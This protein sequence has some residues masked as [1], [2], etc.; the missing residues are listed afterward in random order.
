MSAEASYARA[1]A[2]ILVQ[3]STWN[4][5]EVPVRNFSWRVYRPK[6]ETVPAQGWKLHV[7]CTED[8]IDALVTKVIAPLIERKTS[9]KLPATVRGL[10]QLNDGVGGKAQR[11]KIVTIYPRDEREAAELLR[12]L[13]E[14][15]PAS[16]SPRVA[17]EARLRRES[18]VSARY[19]AFETHFSEDEFGRPER[20]IIN[21]AWPSHR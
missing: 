16:S 4:V 10:R 20:M 14:A 13:D 9:F 11:G 1:L 19:G 12:T 5:E 7:G 21:R 3:P 17:G 18:P 2:A 15:W 6:D 8:E